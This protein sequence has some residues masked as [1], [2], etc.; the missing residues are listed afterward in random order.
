LSRALLYLYILAT[1]LKRLLLFRFPSSD[2]LKISM[3]DD[4]YEFPATSTPVGTSTTGPKNPGAVPK[5]KV[6]G[7]LVSW[8]HGILYNECSNVLALLVNGS[9]CS[10]LILFYYKCS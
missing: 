4:L 3:L 9:V 5:R 8:N 1:V 7:K 2:E 10:A 6:H